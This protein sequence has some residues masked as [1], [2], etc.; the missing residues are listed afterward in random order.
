VGQLLGGTDLWARVLRELRDRYAADAVSHEEFARRVSAALEAQ[1][2]AELTALIPD[3]EVDAAAVT[4]K[5][6]TTPAERQS[7]ERHLSPGEWIAWT[8]HPDPSKHISRADAF[9]IP[10][11]IFWG[12]FAIV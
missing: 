7:L 9:L 8:G 10:F 5:Q 3:D 11:S 6:T 4:L 12:G 2:R 1:S